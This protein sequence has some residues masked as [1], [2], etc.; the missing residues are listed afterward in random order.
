MR[1]VVRPAYIGQPVTHYKQ[2]LQPLLD[3]YSNYCSYCECLGKVDVEHVA[4]A[5][6]NPALITD[7]TNL[8]LGCARCN[9]DFKRNNNQDRQGYVWP[10][11][12][13]TFKLL[14]YYP[15]GRVKPADGLAGIL[16][17]EVAQTI[18]LIRLD[19]SLQI[20]KPLNLARRKTFNIARIFLDHYQNNTTTIAEILEIASCGY[21]S[22]WYT[23]FQPCP[24]VL[25]ALETL[26]S[27][28]DIHRP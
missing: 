8:L 23:V 27:N 26:H 11:K 7:W 6:F 28:T 3:A 2:Y 10:D 22:V 17:Q 24:A 19:D 1:P 21:W 5:S 15:D 9:R 20:Q 4:P 13:N 16:R 25:F 18:D 14:K 12:H